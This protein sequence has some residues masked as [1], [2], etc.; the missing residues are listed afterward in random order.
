[1]AVTAITPVQIAQEV[2]SANLV[3]ASAAIVATAQADGWNVAPP[4]G[5]TIDHML[6]KVI[7]SAAGDTLTFKKGVRPPSARAEMG[8]LVQVFAANE[9]RY[10]L[11]EGARHAQADG[12]VN[13]VA[14]TSGAKLMAICLPK[15]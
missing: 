10:V 13:V 14:S 7:A 3:D 1:M 9:V 15:L 8:D 5:F 12:S 4:S 2:V 6:L 11:L